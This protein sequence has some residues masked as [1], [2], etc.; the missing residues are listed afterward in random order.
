[1]ANPLGVDGFKKAAFAY[2]IIWSNVFSAKS[3]SLSALF[4]LLTVDVLC[5]A[6]GNSNNRLVYFNMLLSYYRPR[7]VIL[8]ILFDI[9]L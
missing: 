1:M 3:S 8:Y 2:T 5:P 4:L 7:A 6:I 9:V